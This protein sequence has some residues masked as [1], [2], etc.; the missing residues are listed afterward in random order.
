[1][2]NSNI[3]ALYVNVN[4]VNSG[5]V[6]PSLKLPIKTTM[7]LHPKKKKYKSASLLLLTKNN[8]ALLMDM[9]YSMTLGIILKF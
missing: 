4:T 8:I 9:P 2:S 3:K 7:L 5:K 6:M 1:M